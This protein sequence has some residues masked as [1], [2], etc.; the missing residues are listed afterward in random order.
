MTEPAPRAWS[1][2]DEVQ[3]RAL[4]GEWERNPEWNQRADA[5]QPE[6]ETAGRWLARIR[7]QREGLVTT[8]ATALATLRSELD[9]ALATTAP[10]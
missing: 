1:D 3:A 5:R 6:E 9:A 4:V 10:A 2:E 8:I 7:E